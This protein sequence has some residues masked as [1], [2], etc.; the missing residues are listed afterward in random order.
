MTNLRGGA[1]EEQARGR[2]VAKRG[3][4]PEKGS[5]GGAGGHWKGVLQLKGIFIALLHHALSLLELSLLF[6]VNLSQPR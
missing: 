2:G 5:L 4:K 1:S 3:S 6:R